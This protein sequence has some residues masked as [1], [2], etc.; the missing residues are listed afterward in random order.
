M[1]VP[2][3]IVEGAHVFGCV[4]LLA[5]LSSGFATFVTARKKD[6]GL[7][8]AANLNPRSFGTSTSSFNIAVMK[9]EIRGFG[10]GRWV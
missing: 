6:P 5:A 3:T 8:F 4:F 7:S 2:L 9:D 10:G 1:A